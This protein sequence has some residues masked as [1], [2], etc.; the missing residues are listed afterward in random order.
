[1]LFMNQTKYTIVC[2]ILKDNDRIHGHVQQEHQ[3]NS[4]I[5]AMQCSFDYNI[6][7]T[8]DKLT[9]VKPIK[10]GHQFRIAW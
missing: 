5:L 8:S 1:M 10:F 6:S 9:H 2:T 7:S 3:G 4:K